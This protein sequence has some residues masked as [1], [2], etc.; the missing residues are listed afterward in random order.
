LSGDIS[1]TDF[2]KGVELA[3]NNEINEDAKFINGSEAVAKVVLET[4]G[5]SV[6]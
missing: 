6:V 1:V 5:F 4:G 3:Y 2:I